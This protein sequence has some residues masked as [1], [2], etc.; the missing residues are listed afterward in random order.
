MSSL[1]P[2]LHGAMAIADWGLYLVT[3]EELSAGRTTAEVVDAAIE[4]GASVVQLREKAQHA[5][6]RYEIGREVRALTAEAGVDFVVNDRIDLAMAL[7]ADGV[8]LGQEDLPVSVAREL[9]GE[10]AIVGCSVSTV[11]EARTAAADGADYLGVGTVFPTG[12]KDVRDE[13]VIGVDGVRSIREAVDLPLVAIGG[14]DATNAGRVVEAGADAVAVISAVTQAPDVAS[15]AGEL[16]AAVE[17]A[18]E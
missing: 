1:L 4:G 9:L 17:A 14:I 15:A 6:R 13:R 11:D 2:L 18:S 16:A 5:R 8:H 7:D 12:S 3:G 10:D